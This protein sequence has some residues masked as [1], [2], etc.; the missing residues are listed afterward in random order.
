MSIQTY[1]TVTLKNNQLF[2]T[3]KLTKHCNALKVSNFK[4]SAPGLAMDARILEFLEF[5]GFVTF[6]VGNVGIFE[7]CSVLQGLRRETLLC[8]NFVSCEA[9]KN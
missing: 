1:I 2:P 7:D 5:F 6:R 4:E 9:V 3:L 8:S